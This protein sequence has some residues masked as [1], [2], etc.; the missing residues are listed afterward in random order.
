[1]SFGPQKLAELTPAQAA[2]LLL[3]RRRMRESLIGFAESIT[4]PGAPVSEE[5]NEA[6]FEPVGSGVALHHKLFMQKIQECMTKRYGRL[7]IFAPPGSAKS[8]YATVVGATWYL[9][10]FPG[11]RI[12][13]T[14]YG[15][16]LAKKHGRKAR[17][18]VK[19]DVFQG[20]FGCSMSSD[21]GAAEMWTLTNGSEYMSGGILSGVT[22]NRANCLIIDDPVKGREEANSATVRAKIREAYEDD[23]TTRLL[24]GGCVILIQTRWHPEDLAG[25]ILPEDYDGRS[26]PVICR[27]GQVWEIV[28][29]PAEC[30]YADD[31]L[32][33]P[34]GDGKGGV[35]GSMLWED[36][37]DAQ[38]WAPKRLQKRTWAALY[39]Q[40]PKIEEDTR[41]RREWV[42]RYVPGTQPKWLRKYSASDYAVTEEDREKKNDPDFTEHGIAGVDQ[43]GH[44]WFLDWWS[45]QAES[46]VTIKALLDLADKHGVRRGFGEVGVIRRAIEPQFRTMKRERRGREGCRFSPSLEIEYLPHIGDKQAKLDAFL[47]MCSAGMVHFPDHTCAWAERVL[48]QLENFPD[49]RFKDDAVDVCGLFGRAVSDMVWSKEESM[50]APEPALKFGS[51]AWLKY[52]TEP[53]DENVE[54]RTF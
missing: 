32:G 37:F 10:K 41:F 4:I 15:T 2:A 13:L 53:G 23:L 17:S 25:G 33:R 22:G 11:S 28:N 3:K 39:Q 45:K 47:S 38:H 26:G 12:I 34:I 6:I 21:V 54:P 31:P 19:Q 44:L 52:G 9:G 29:L 51:M 16:E 49:T 46:D 8:T 27:D 36:F 18:V 20:A 42:Q 14:S 7:M 48:T 1:M 35:P 5:E 50:P 43:F 40:R 30:E 24:P